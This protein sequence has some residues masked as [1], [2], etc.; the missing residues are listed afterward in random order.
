MA[1]DPRYSSNRSR[2][3]NRQELCRLLAE[4]IARRNMGDWLESL[5]AVGV[6][7]GPI[8]TLDKVFSDPQISARGMVQE[9]NHPLAGAVKTVASPIRFSRTPVNRGSAPP[10][11]GQH[12]DEIFE[13]VDTQ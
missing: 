9:V 11:L 6:P 12:N 4:I 10:L 5:E 2:V 1:D 13:D 3:E 7:C 8:N